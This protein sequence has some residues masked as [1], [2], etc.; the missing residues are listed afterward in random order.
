MYIVDTNTYY[1][2][3][4]TIIDTKYIPGSEGCR[5]A[6]ADGAPQQAHRLLQRGGGAEHEST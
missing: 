5:G 3:Y 4:N 6:G 2:M 1:I